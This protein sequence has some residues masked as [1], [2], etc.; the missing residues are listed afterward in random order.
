MYQFGG[1]PH[2]GLNFGCLNYFLLK[3]LYGDA[4]DKWLEVFQEF[5]SK[6]TFN[7]V[8]TDELGFSLHGLSSS[9]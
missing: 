7:N 2:F 5:N 6:G 8:F 1:R 4:L 9:H 3:D